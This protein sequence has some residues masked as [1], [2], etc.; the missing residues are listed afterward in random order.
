LAEASRHLDLDI[1]ARLKAART[2]RRLSQRELARKSGVTNG[3]ISQIEQNRSSPSVSSLKR[4]LDAIPMSMSAF[5]A[6]E[7]PDRRQIFFAAD[8]LR[9]INPSK[10]FRNRGA[11]AISFRQVG[12]SSAHQIQMLHERYAAGS[13]T[14]AEMYAHDGEEA[15]IVISGRI[16]V[17]VGEDIRELGPGEAYLFDS[18]IP[19][20]FRTFG[21]EDCEIISAC[22]PPTF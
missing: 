15:G 8:E 12:D 19:H 11:S 17:T 7:F 2:E 1:G 21:D 20:R 22:T 18:R 14:G 10:L 6:D 9:E 16:E 3:L 13:D 5:F 4:I